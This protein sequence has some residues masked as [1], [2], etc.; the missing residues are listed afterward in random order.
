MHEDFIEVK[1]EK[2]GVWNSKK[3]RITAQY[4]QRYN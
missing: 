1:I 2:I 4:P 3:G